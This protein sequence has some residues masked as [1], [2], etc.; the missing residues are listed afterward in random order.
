MP[1]WQ[2]ARRYLVVRSVIIRRRR[3]RNL[4]TIDERVEDRHGAVGDTSVWVNLLEHWDEKSANCFRRERVSVMNEGSNP[5]S[6][7]SRCCGRAKAPENGRDWDEDLDRT[8]VDVRRVCLLASLCSLFLVTSRRG[9][10]ASFLLLGG[11]LGGRCLRGGLLLSCG[12]GRHF[13][14]L[15]G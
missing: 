5:L 14:K 9:L 15:G 12:F 6:V 4:L 2:R 7:V 13:G 10:L 1:Q 11:G 3:D 8:F